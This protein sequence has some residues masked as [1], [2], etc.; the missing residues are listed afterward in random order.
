MAAQN[1]R[2]LQPGEYLCLQ[3][4]ESH[5]IF[6]LRSGKLQVF[7]V[8]AEGFVAQDR[9]EKEGMLVGE[10]EQAGSFIGEI[11][12]ILNEPRSASMRVS[13]DGPAQV[14]VINLRGKGFAQTVA[15]NP[16][17]GFGLAKT[18]AQRVGHTS[19]SITRS[20]SLAL[21]AKG[22]LEIYTRGIY[23]AAS[24]FQSAAVKKHEA[25]VA[26]S[27]DEEKKKEAPPEPKLVR[28][29]KETLPYQIGRMVDKYGSVPMEIYAAVSSPFAN[30]TDIFK[31][32]IISGQEGGGT[33]EA[34][35]P[36]GPPKKGLVKF[37]P[38]QVVCPEQSVDE[39]MYILIAGKLEVYLGNRS[40]ELIKGKGDIFS[41]NAMF[42]GMERACGV[43][44]LTEVHAMPLPAKKIE[45]FLMAKPAVMV[46][47]LRSFAKRLPL[48]N[49]TLLSTANQL[50]QIMNILGLSPDSCML[51]L[52]TY[53]S[54]FREQA[55][56]Y[57]SEGEQAAS[58]MEELLEQIGAEFN[59]INEDYTEFC[60]EIGF[61]PKEEDDT[62][63]G[64]G[65]LPPAKFDFV[66]KLEMLET[67]EVEHANFVMNPK[68][69][70]FRACAI[71]YDHEALLKQAKVSEAKWSEFI[72]GRIHNF[73]ES[74]PIMFITLDLDNMGKA[75]HERDY[76]MR[77][78]QFIVE[79]SEQEAAILFKDGHSLE[80]MH[81][82]DHIKLEDELVDEDTI[83]EI[84][85]AFK[86]DPN[87]RENL[88]KLNGMFWD[89]VAATVTKKLPKVKDNVIPFEE[90][91]L[92]LINFGLFDKD[93]VPAEGN[94][95]NR[96]EED[97]NFEPPEEQE[98]MGLEYI[99]LSDSLQDMYKEAFGY[100][101]HMDMVEELKDYEKKVKETQDR[102]QAITSGRNEMVRS[103]P[104]GQAAGQFV[105]K[106]DGLV[107]ATAV[108]DRK[109]KAGASISNEERA[110]I[111]QTRN[112]K[113]QLKNQINKFLTTIKGRVS[114]DQIKQFTDLGEELENKVIQELNDKAELAKKQQGVKDHELEMKGISIKQKETAYKNEVI[115]IKKYALLMAKKVKVD[116]MAVLVN[117]REI[118]NKTSVSK[119]LEL[120]LSEKVD[121][122]IF[123]ESLPR[124]KK[125]GIPRIM[126][127][128]GSGVAVYD[129][130]KHVFMIPMQYP[131]SLEESLANAFVEFHWDMD[132]DKSL[133]ESYGDLKIYKKLSYTKLKQQLGK[134]YVI[135]ATQESKGWKKLDKEVRA[136]FQV[137]IAKQKLEDK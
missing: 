59:E 119:I 63:G 91:D 26:E 67:L 122:E 69:D 75:K 3:G 1:I 66:T 41:E 126:L 110:K 115:R 135:W 101:K 134:D 13:D 4:D 108:L 117:V 51:L 103:F 9:V 114:D 83:N 94:V 136:W 46:H 98:E 48:L 57:G 31:N 99:Y 47:V 118:A 130:E 87:D 64:L 30:H 11:G 36:Q 53:A 58:K 40:I 17:I 35:E 89:L 19:N 127:I 39:T 16:K 61:K 12:A 129:W 37:D 106:L 27:G 7:V 70:Q 80:L 125:D 133:R 34:P 25:E 79:R 65:A 95:L 23:E 131:K 120:F 18:I 14:M 116:P 2:Q 128:P 137:K 104:G 78:L 68:N 15:G 74:F 49:D 60:S 123:D 121:P 56:D 90:D 10:I 28:E 20:D 96:I 109:M 124:I 72:F 54:Q 111:V 42:G 38:G 92:N 107:K 105:A 6:V 77:A 29:L 93:F 112:A 43:R 50:A 62:G 85:E 100:N 44:A 113:Q 102:I 73:G 97:K 45:P 5:E 86:K 22:L 81:I 21:K 33:P 24:I 76:A 52:E 82:P 71:E 32:R 8:D 84:Q 55:A 132:E 88:E